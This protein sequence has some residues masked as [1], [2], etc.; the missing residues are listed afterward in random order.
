MRA[1]LPVVASTILSMPGCEQPTITTIPSGELIASESLRSSGS[2]ACQGPLRGPRPAARTLL[3]GGAKV[4]QQYLAAGLVD[5]MDLNLAPVFLGRGSDCSRIWGAICRGSSW[6]GRCRRPAS[7]TCVTGW[8]E[9]TG[10]PRRP[11]L[12]Y[13]S[14]GAPATR[15]SAARRGAART[16][17]RIGQHPAAQRQRG[18]PR[19]KASG[20]GTPGPFVEAECL[21][22]LRLARPT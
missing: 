9:P 5:Q 15:A 20:S 17:K 4:A 6:Y 8:A 22:L 3:L 11:L 10:R 2:R 7:L 12:A 19:S 16:G 21:P 13:H 14:G 18:C 1:L